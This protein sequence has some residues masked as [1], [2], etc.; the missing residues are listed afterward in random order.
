MTKITF[1]GGEVQVDAEIIGSGL[2]IDPASVQRLIREGLITSRHERGEGAD[3]GRSRL[4]FFHGN[5]RFHLIVGA[6]G[7]IVQ[8]SAI[9]FGDMP[10]PAAL[11]R[12]GG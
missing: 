1:D 2:D 3:A 8:R 12:P 6:D 5:R 11:R 10:L 7:E 4:T 9:D